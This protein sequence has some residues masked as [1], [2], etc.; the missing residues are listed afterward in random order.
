M[1]FAGDSMGARTGPPSR[2]SGRR[3]KV[4][5]GAI[6]VLH[7]CVKVKNRLQCN[8]ENRKRT[9]AWRLGGAL[10]KSYAW[11]VVGLVRCDDIVSQ[12]KR[13]FKKGATVDIRQTDKKT[14]T[15]SVRIPAALA[16]ELRAIAQ[17]DD[18]AVGRTARAA[19]IVGMKHIKAL[20]GIG[21]Q[22][23]A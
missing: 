16:S 14:E 10:S 15:V 20:R 11:G 4:D 12:Q 23:T 13:F 9:H 6:F 7:V 2:Q 3:W 17:A 21:P 19:L 1:S 5:S 18:V 22:P 8:S